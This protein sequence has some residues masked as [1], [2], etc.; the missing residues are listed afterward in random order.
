ML[1]FLSRRMRARNFSPNMY[2]YLQNY[3][4]VRKKMKIDANTLKK[5]LPLIKNYAAR[6][7]KNENQKFSNG[8]VYY[9][10]AISAIHIVTG[11]HKHE[12]TRI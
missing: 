5:A 11:K 12:Y 1:M 6:R 2:K 4:F 10:N 7:G 8:D 3:S 9:G